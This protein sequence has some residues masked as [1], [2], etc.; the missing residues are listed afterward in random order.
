MKPKPK[1]Q[2]W[3][4]TTK[5]GVAAANW[6]GNG[7]GEVGLEFNWGDSLRISA[8]SLT[9]KEHKGLTI[10]HWLNADWVI[11]KVPVFNKDNVFQGYAEQKVAISALE[12]LHG[13][14]GELLAFRPHG[15]GV[16]A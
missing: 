9:Q 2:Q 14:I 1:P 16:S 13:Y 3:M 5:G 12:K 4:P 6:L 8:D 10:Q 15:G 11:V 7:D